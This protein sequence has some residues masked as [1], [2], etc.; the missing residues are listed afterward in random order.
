MTWVEE[1]KEEGK[2]WWVG[3]YGRKLKVLKPHREQTATSGHRLS[4]TSSLPRSQHISLSPWR[5]LV[6][7]NSLIKT[8]AS[9]WGLELDLSY[10]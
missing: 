4:G 3:W 8:G 6:V 2:A 7:N 10:G 1:V 5:A 9:P